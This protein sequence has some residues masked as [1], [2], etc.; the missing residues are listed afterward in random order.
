MVVNPVDCHFRFNFKSLREYRK[1]F[2][3]SIAERPEACHN[4]LDFT[5]K[6]TVDAG[7]HQGIS[8]IVEGS[9]VFF[10]IGGG[11]PVPHHHIRIVMKNLVHHGRRKFHGIGVVAIHHD[12]ALCVYFTEHTPDDVAFPLHILLP[13]DCSFLSGNFP[14][15]VRGI[16]VIYINYCLRQG[17]P[18]VPYYLGNGF[19]FII[20]WNQDCNFIHFH[21]PLS[22]QSRF[23]RPRCPLLFYQSLH[24]KSSYC[25]KPSYPLYY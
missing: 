9:F 10:K 11:K 22:V 5:A 13:Y 8:H 7:P 12:I 6:Q 17:L 3:K 21:F 19:F 23:S 20:A 15:F 2:Y 16:V 25:Q 14:C 18:A 1:G 24:G 4:I